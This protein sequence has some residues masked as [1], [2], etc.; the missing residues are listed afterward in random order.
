MDHLSKEG[1]S[2]N[3]SKIRSKNT[4]PELLFR[5]AIHKKGYRY[6][7]HH[8]KLPGKPDLYFPKY[9]TALFIHG[10]FWH[11]H[12][13][14][15]RKSTPKSNQDYWHPKLEGNV[16]RFEQARKTLEE[17]KIKV[18]VLWECEA[19]VIDLAVDQFIQYM[20]GKPASPIYEIAP[21]TEPLYAASPD[22]EEL[23]Y[24]PID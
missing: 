5:S 2:K 18:Y 21:D 10:C 9:K 8:K 20:T 22:S 13:G 19:K 16:R 3:M 11:Q 12:P 24:K 23:L 14:C 6:S 15:K 17:K 7:L 4:K 1:R